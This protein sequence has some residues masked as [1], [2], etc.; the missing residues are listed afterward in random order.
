M[1]D[2]AK[3]TANGTVNKTAANRL[4]EVMLEHN[5]PRAFTSADA[6]RTTP[7]PM[8]LTEELGLVQVQDTAATEV[9]VNQV[10]AVNQKAVQDVVKNPKK[11]KAAAGFLCGQVMKLS[12]VKADPNLVRRIIE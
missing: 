2:L 12:S 4:A 8:Q 7:S 10:F 3:I 1:A 11:A 5:E 6:Q 9:W